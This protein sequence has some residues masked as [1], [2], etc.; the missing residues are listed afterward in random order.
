MVR[1]GKGGVVPNCLGGP[2]GLDG[3][4][5][6]VGKRLPGLDGRAGMQGNSEAPGALA[7]GRARSPTQRQASR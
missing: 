3:E 6:A 5:D 4:L 7:A 1:R 2:Q